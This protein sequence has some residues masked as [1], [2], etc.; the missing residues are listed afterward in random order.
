MVSLL[1]KVLHQL[2]RK[3]IQVPIEDKR[4]QKT[5]T[6]PVGKFGLQTLLRLDAGDSYDFVNFPAMLY[7]ID[8]GD[9][10]ILQEYLEKRYNQFNGGY[11]SGISVMRQVSGATQGRYRQIAK[12]G[13]TALLGNAMNTPDIYRRWPGI[14]LGDGFRM[15]VK[16]K[17]N[18]LFI[19]GSLDSNTPISNVAEIEKGFPNSNYVIV[20]NAGHEDMLPNEAVQRLV[21][22]Y[23]SGHGLTTTRVVLPKPNFVAVEPK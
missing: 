15:P 5:V 10:T 14:D 6:I 20:Q 2:D 23:L 16:S 22:E 19:S 17:V 9:Y 7:G 4:A 8:K 13:K 12:E 1:K 18:T 3:R 11:G 21:V